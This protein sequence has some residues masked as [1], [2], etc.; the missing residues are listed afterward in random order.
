M[1]KYNVAILGCGAIFNRHLASLQAN[2]EHFSLI[3]IFDTDNDLM[4]KYQHELNVKG[5]T[6]E[7]EVFADDNVNCIIILTPSALHFSQAKQALLAGKHVI[8][9][10]PATFYSHEIEELENIAKTKQLNIFSVLQVRLNPAVIVAKQSISEGLFGKIRSVSLIQRWQRPSD[11][12]SGWR[13]NM[14]TGG[15][16][17]REFAIHY[18]DVLQYLVGQPKISHANFFNTKFHSTD[19]NDT[20]YALLDFDSHGG[21]V[22][23]SIS[24][25]PKNLECTLSIMSDQGFLKLGGK[26]LDEIINADFL[27][28]ATKERFT[29][30]QQEI[31]SLKTADLVNVGASPYHPELYRRIIFNPEQFIL[32][33]TYNVIKL[34]ENVYSLKA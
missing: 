31:A 5:Y 24:A 30:I 32:R 1:K 20:I 14:E 19:V 28:E 22:E 33:Q 6:L 21:S 10:K 25:E 12:F 8:V 11:Y 3:G 9:E 2:S 15:G 29:Q 18:L 13:G 7:K 17:L 23:V 34:V 4:A 26:S 27:N 16:I